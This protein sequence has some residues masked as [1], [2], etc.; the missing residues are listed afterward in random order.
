MTQGDINDL[1][2]PDEQEL[3]AP[4]EIT[5][6]PQP[7]QPPGLA[8]RAAFDIACEAYQRELAPLGLQL[9]VEVRLVPMRPHE[10]GPSQ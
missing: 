9:L 4:A 5:Q 7:P 6:L 1:P 10:E 3:P 8:T 2:Q